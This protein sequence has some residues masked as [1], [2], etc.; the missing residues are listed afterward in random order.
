VEAD[1]CW[2]L[3][4]EVREKMTLEQAAAANCLCLGVAVF[5]P[6]S[7]NFPGIGQ[8]YVPEISQTAPT[9]PPP[10]PEKPPEPEIP[11]RPE[12]PEDTTDQIQ[13]AQFLNELETYMDDVEQIQTG[14]KNEMAMHEA[15]ANIYQEEMIAYQ[16]EQAKY[17]IA[18]NS[19]VQT[20]QGMISSMKEEFGWAWVDKHDP[21]VYRSWL[22]RAWIAQVI[23]MFV[24]FILILL[25][26]KRKDVK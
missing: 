8:Y 3:P 15:Q 5:D 13:V 20:A 1:V 10:L 7:C 9:E 6:L 23:I 22:T 2:K 25:L 17:D 11:P 21:E 19:A 26:I 24:Y 14:Y 18:R 12:S 4:E 16:K